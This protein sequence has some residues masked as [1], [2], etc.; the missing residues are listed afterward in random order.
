LVIDDDP[1]VQR[2]VTKMLSAESFQVMAAGSVADGYTLM[3]SRR[4]LDST[5]NRIASSLPSAGNT[6]GALPDGVRPI[7]ANPE[8]GDYLIE[9]GSGRSQP[10]HHSIEQTPN[11]TSGVS[12]VN[13]KYYRVWSSVKNLQ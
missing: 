7:Q 9:W 2:I 13:S 11:L 5:D 1:I 6:G 3:S 10:D 12:H 4:W 8:F